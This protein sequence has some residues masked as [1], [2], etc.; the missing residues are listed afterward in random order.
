MASAYMLSR[1]SSFDRVRIGAWEIAAHAG[2]VEADPYTQA[3]VERSSDIPLSVGEGLQLIARADDDGRPLDGRCIYQVGKHVPAARYWTLSLI[4]PAGF[5]VEN[6]AKRYGFRSSEI[7]RRR[8]RLC[9]HGVCGRATGQLAAD[10]KARALR[11]RPPSLRFAAGSDRR[12]H[13]EVCGAGGDQD[14]LRMRLRSLA[15]QGRFILRRRRSSLSS[16]I[17]SSS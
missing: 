15:G 10:W 8:R 14:L 2:A 11:A 9:H 13:R 17:W 7:S 6:A 5:P 16:F 4:S 12:R 1:S 3:N